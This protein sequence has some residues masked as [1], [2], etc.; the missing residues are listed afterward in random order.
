MSQ[1]L[2]ELRI[3]RLSIGFEILKEMKR[4]DEFESNQDD[5]E[6]YPI[7][8]IYILTEK[9]MEYF[10]EMGYED[11]LKEDGSVWLP[12]NEYWRHTFKA[13][14]ELLRKEG[15]YLEFIRKEGEKGFKGNW[16]FCDKK[17]FVGKMKQEHG[18]ISTR[19]EGYNDRIDDGCLKW[20][21]GLPNIN[22]VPAIT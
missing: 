9:M 20:K 10:Y 3:S 1:E 13:V 11:K 7:T 8:D 22:P 21:I 12:N 4:N 17:V 18:E 6:K 15:L 2:S 16:L 5:T 14:R 19:T